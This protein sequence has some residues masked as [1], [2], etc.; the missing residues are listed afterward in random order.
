MAS[1]ESRG[2]LSGGALTA[3]GVQAR[4]QLEVDTDET[5]AHL[6]ALLGSGADDLIRRA[7]ALSDRVMDAVSFPPDP[8]KRAAG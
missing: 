4:L 6:I 1:L 8:R 3:D 7:A 2:W 5:Q